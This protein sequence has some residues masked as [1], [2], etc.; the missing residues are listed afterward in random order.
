MSGRGKKIG[1]NH[2]KRK[3]QHPSDFRRRLMNELNRSSVMV[4]QQM[5]PHQSS[6]WAPPPHV[7]QG[8]QNS[9]NQMVMAMPPP[10][11]RPRNPRPPHT[12]TQRRNDYYG[13]SE[14]LL[15]RS[16]MSASSS[17][18]ST[19]IRTS[20]FY[21]NPSRH[22][23]MRRQQRNIGIRDLQAAMK[24]GTRRTQRGN[25]GT[26][27]SI[28]EYNGITYIV[29]DSTGTEITSYVS[30]VPLDYKTIPPA[31]Y[32]N[33]L[34]AKKSLQTGNTD[35]KSIMTSHSVLLVDTSGSMRNSDVSGSKS[36]LE[37]VWIAVAQ[38]YVAQRITAGHAG[39]TDAVT[40]I[41]MGE[42][43]KVHPVINCVP[44]DW[45]LYNALM[46]QIM[47]RHSIQHVSPRGHGCYKPSMEMAEQ[48]L[49][50]YESSSCALVLG[51]FSDGRPSDYYVERVQ[52]KRSER[53]HPTTPTDSNSDNVASLSK[54]EKP[55]DDSSMIESLSEMVGRMASK[56][57]RRL[58]V[59]MIGMGS[60]DKFDALQSM[61]N[62]AD[63]YGARGVFQLP[64][65][66]SSAM[67]N[68]MSSVGTSL[69]NSQ[70]ELTS[71]H[72][73]GGRQRK[74]RKVTRE[75]RTL[76]PLLTEVIDKD[77]F[78]IYMGDTVNHMI[79][80]ASVPG[81]FK[82]APLQHPEARGVAVKKQPFGEG[83]E[84]LAYQ[85]FEIAEDG[86]TVVG[87]PLVAKV[88][89]FVEERENNKTSDWEDH[90]K[91]ARRFCTLQ[92]RARKAAVAF[93]E[94]LDGITLLD[95][96]TARVAFLD[97]SVYY[98]SDPE[99]GEHSVIVERRLDGN[100]Q[101]WNTNNGWHRESSKR[102]ASDTFAARSS[103][104][105][106][107]EDDSD[108]NIL[109]DSDSNCID[110]DANTVFVTKD[111]VAQAFSHFS[112]FHSGKQA[113]ICDLQGVYDRPNR[114]LN[115]T[116]PVIHYHA[117]T[118][119]GKCKRG[120]YGRTDH[121][122]KGI[123][124]FMKTHVCNALCQ[125]VTKGFKTP[126]ESRLKRQKCNED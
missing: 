96:D 5:A 73:D 88:S 59:A 45:V 11:P 8:Q 35:G 34:K 37:A 103:L 112:Y 40:I 90:D 1:T 41:L 39:S 117:T 81:K 4:P 55:G 125:F 92:H 78:D 32:Q 120:V 46:D 48:I 16:S 115:F 74:V 63:K 2:S 84:R 60:A 111:E 17:P 94:N 79:Y 100:F 68:A 49:T 62:E 89:R 19:L 36:R 25:G 97:C 22:G 31:D 82:K 42:T 7:P 101:K 116:D 105:V 98:M 58:T 21:I 18:S 66:T 56:L 104:N 108:K 107:R 26:T 23:E 124:N 9:N 50:Q 76:I 64:S 3:M 13:P 80:D 71:V 57:G 20:D 109:N 95:D 119:K 102:K 10:P 106:I 54:G 121:G 44:T 91:F 72:Y 67:G 27:K 87:D 51:V 99:K 83:G 14:S 38:D 30:R 118:K 33:H 6:R 52:A 85:F 15:P 93:N 110:V 69:I 24:H 53:L 75:N 113:L 65:L 86:E 61:A 28:Y 70:T 29:N 126:H 12:S 77:E 122:H 43:A 123:S 47:N 114:R